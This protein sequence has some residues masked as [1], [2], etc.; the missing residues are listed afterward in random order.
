MKLYQMRV[1]TCFLLILFYSCNDKK[2]ILIDVADWKP[3]DIVRG[4]VLNLVEEEYLI[5]EG[6]LKLSSTLNV[7]YD[8]GKIVR[9]VY[10]D[11]HSDLLI[12]DKFYNENGALIKSKNNKVKEFKQYVYENTFVDCYEIKDTT[13][14]LLFKASLNSNNQI[15][16]L[17]DYS[18]D[19][20]TLCYTLYTY[21][22][23]LLKS[24]QAYRANGLLFRNENYFYNSDKT[25]S[26]RTSTVIMEVNDI[27]FNERY[28]YKEYD[29]NRNW[30]ICEHYN[31]HNEL[32]SIYK[33]RYKYSN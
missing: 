31:M 29:A 9:S 33:R 6:S 15:S 17:V 5:K 3:E 21:R 30:T 1:F 20:D 13:K 4:S 28:V 27:V 24:V 32:S 8:K 14:I 11:T 10:S 7:E 25:L 23:E 12:Y 2:P 16:S 22:K 19:N 18:D 26:S